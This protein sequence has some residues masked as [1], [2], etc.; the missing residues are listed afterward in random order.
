MHLQ[1][2][3]AHFVQEQCAAIGKLEYADLVMIGACKRSFSMAEQL[4]FQQRVVESRAIHG[5]DGLARAWTVEVNVAR[6]QLFA[7]A[8]FTWINTVALVPDTF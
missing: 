5:N 4:A 2:D 6:D 8:A 3:V 7:C 1:A